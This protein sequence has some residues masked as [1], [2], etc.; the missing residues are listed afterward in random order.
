MIL[1]QYSEFQAKVVGESEIGDPEC[2][3]VQPILLIRFNLR[4]FR[5]GERFSFVDPSELAQY[6]SGAEL[7]EVM[8]LQE[9]KA[10]IKAAGVHRCV[11]VGL[12]PGAEW[13]VHPVA[14]GIREH[15]V[16]AQP[17]SSDV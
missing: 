16:V 8:S 11:A 9:Q 1:N 12:F 10:Q 13:S 4:R 15:G 2:R 14:T 7:S 6:I 5:S 17:T 3:H